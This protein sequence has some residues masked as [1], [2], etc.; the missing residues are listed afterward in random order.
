MADT[1]RMKLQGLRK[2]RFIVFI[3]AATLVLTAC[4]PMTSY[5]PGSQIV[6][7][8]GRTHTVRRS[9]DTYTALMNNGLLQGKATEAEVYVGNLRAIRDATGCPVAMGTVKNEGGQT[10][11]RLA[12]PAEE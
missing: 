9:G 3:V 6:S 5:L 7:V 1:E 4:A 12:C 11:A 10:I 8:D 2:S